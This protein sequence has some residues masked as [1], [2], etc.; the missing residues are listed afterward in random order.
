MRMSPSLKVGAYRN[1]PQIENVPLMQNCS[2]WM[3]VFL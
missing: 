1:I 2:M 3:L